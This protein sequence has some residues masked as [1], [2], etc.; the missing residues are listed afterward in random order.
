[1]KKNASTI[2]YTLFAFLLSFLF[3][4]YTQA[5]DKSKELA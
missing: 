2:N 4:N 3:L 1:M 5:Q